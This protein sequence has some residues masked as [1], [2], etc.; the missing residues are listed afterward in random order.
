MPE[1]TDVNRTETVLPIVVPT[2]LII[3]QRT[4]VTSASSWP[5]RGNVDILV[6]L[7]VTSLSAGAPRVEHSDFFR[8]C[9]DFVNLLSSSDLSSRGT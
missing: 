5:I 2:R 1:L 9:L 7:R 8:V 3:S 6:D 4:P